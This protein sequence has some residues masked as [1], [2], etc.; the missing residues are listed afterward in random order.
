MVRTMP[1]DTMT[2]GVEIWDDDDEEWRTTF[3]EICTPRN[4]CSPLCKS[5]DCIELVYSTDEFKIALERKNYLEEQGDKARI[6][7]LGV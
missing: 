1:I 5:D 6:K 7:E 3:I 4:K 2:Y